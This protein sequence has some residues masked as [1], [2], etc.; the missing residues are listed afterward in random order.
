MRLQG[1]QHFPSQADALPCSKCSVNTFS[2]RTIYSG[3]FHAGAKGV[4]DAGCGGQVLLSQ[5]G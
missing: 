4:S 1:Q 5:V 3:D 2:G